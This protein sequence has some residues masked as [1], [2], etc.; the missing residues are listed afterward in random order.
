MDTFKN[1]AQNV[2][3]HEALAS[4]ALKDFRIIFSSVKKHSSQIEE[5]CDISSSQLWVLWEL[6]KTPGLKV[7][8]L[9]D[10]LAIHQST[11]SNLIEKIQKKAFICKKREDQDQRVVR[12][13]LTDAGSEIVMKAPDSPRGVLREAIDRLTTQDLQLLQKSLERLISQIKLKDEADAM[14]PLT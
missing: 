4:S 5:Q 14:H 9:A 7:S 12:L 3:S 6:Q 11:A 8:E 13:Y 1:I 10:K 2:L